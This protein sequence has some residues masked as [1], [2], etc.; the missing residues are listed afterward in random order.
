MGSKGKSNGSAQGT[1]SA[2]TASDAAAAAALPAST[3]TPVRSVSSAF[4]TLLGGAKLQASLKKIEPKLK[5]F[6][7]YKGQSAAKAIALANEGAELV[8][9]ADRLENSAARA[10]ARGVQIN[11]SLE[12]FITALAHCAAA[13]DPDSDVAIALAAFAVAR[14]TARGESKRARTVAKKKRAPKTAAAS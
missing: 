12:P 1:T 7:D 13:A 14:T 3:A 2:A 4:V 11:A 5:A 9:I 10:H 6:K 8:G